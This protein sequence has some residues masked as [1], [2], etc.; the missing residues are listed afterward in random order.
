MR[1]RHRE[2]VYEE[3]IE[4]KYQDGEAGGSSRSRGGQF[5]HVSFCG[6]D[7]YHR[8]DHMAAH[9]RVVGIDLSTD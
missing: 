1:Y 3:H 6:S 9:I 2:N 5:R 4:H 7:F 8:E